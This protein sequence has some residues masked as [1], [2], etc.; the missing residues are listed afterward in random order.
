MNKD[1]FPWYPARFRADTM[2]LTAEQDG[3]YRRLIDHYMET[4]V[5]LPDNDSALARISGIAIDSWTIAAAILRPFFK[6]KDGKLFHKK[7]EEVLADQ[8]ARSKKNAEKGKAGAKKRWKSDID[9]PNE[10]SSGHTSTTESESQQDGTRQDRTGQDSN[11]ED[12]KT[13]SSSAVSSKIS[14]SY[15]ARKFDG[16]SDI[17]VESWKA[18]YPAI[19]IMVE[20]NKAAVWLVANP[21]NRK[22]NLERF[23]ANWMAKQQ[24]RAPALGGG[25][26]AGRAAQPELTPDERE[27]NRQ[28]KQKMGMHA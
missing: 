2:H 21:K 16:I 4:G 6:P 10:N 3:I 25:A 24:E 7:C 15:E 13:S 26:S 27:K 19:D 12:D 18:A 22:R 9:I 20:V 11:E 23:L 17:H 14:F 8:L 28:W 5:A 1:W